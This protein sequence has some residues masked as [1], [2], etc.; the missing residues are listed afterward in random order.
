[1]SYNTSVSSQVQNI[2]GYTHY[3][4]FLTQ[5][6]TSAP[7]ADTEVNNFTG[8]T[9]TWARTSAGLYTVTASSAVFTANETAVIM[10]TPLSS[11]NTFNAVI[12]STTVITLTTALSSVIATVLAS[13]ATDALLTNSL[14]EIRVYN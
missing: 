14:L 13:V 6:G 4:A 11:L 5:S 10:S 8:V 1:M 2:L 12:T 9:F 7:S 3:A